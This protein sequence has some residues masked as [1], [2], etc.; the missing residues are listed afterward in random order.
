MKLKNPELWAECVKNNGSDPYSGVAVRFAERW[1]NLME[2]HMERG[3]KLPDC[4]KRL[5]HKADTEY[6]T[7]FLY[8]CAVGILSEVWVHGETLRQWHNL[9]AQLKD[10]GERANKEGGVLN[11]AVMTIG[12]DE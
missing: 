8:G 3:E 4:A 12:G 11:P 7:G 2:E 5:S 10:E 9:N 1:A 6:I